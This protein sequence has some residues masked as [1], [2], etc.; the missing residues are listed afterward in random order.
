MVKYWPND[1][2][3]ALVN[4]VSASEFCYMVK[5]SGYNVVYRLNNP[6]QNFNSRAV[7]W[8][9]KFKLFISS[10]IGGLSKATK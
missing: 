2:Q 10:Q 9:N 1:M 8:Q 4:L 6:Y 5:K 7:S 3:P